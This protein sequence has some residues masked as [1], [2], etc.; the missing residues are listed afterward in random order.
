MLEE[1]LRRT[2]ILSDGS[3]AIFFQR[4]ISAGLLAAATVVLLIVLLPAIGKKR[5]VVFA[6]EE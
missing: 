3:A 6:E 5:N 1:Y 4:P 2:M